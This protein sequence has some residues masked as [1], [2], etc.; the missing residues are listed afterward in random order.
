MYPV[1]FYGD[2]YAG[3]EFIEDDV[4]E[5]VPKSPDP[6]NL[7]IPWFVERLVGCAYGHVDVASE[8]GRFASAVDEYCVA[9]HFCVDQMEMYRFF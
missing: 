9:Q 2:Y 1:V 7:P 5:L 3:E 4:D 6:E 8:E